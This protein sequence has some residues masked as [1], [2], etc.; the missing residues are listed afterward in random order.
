MLTTDGQTD[1]V[2][3][4]CAYLQVLAANVPKKIYDNRGS[5][6]RKG[7]IFV[8]VMKRGDRLDLLEKT[9]A[10]DQRGIKY[11]PQYYTDIFIDV[12]LQ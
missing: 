4:I 5:D 1:R 10:L 6:P 12:G 2:K 3:I 9:I 11:T 8:F 7:K